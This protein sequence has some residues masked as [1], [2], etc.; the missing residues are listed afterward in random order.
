MRKP[1]QETS[2]RKVT[3]ADGKLVGVGDR[4]FNYYDGEWGVIESID[5]HAQPDTMKGQTTA[6]PVEEW[7]NYWFTHLAD[8]GGRTSLDGSR[9]SSYEP[10]R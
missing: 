10:R 7:D 1:D 3:T 4:V 6:T 5:D 8:D 9:V 2:T